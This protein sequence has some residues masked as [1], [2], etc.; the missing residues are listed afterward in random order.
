MQTIGDLIL[1][2]GILFSQSGTTPEDRKEDMSETELELV[3][4]QTLI[5]EL[6]ERF[7]SCI[8][9]GIPFQHS[10][11]STI[12]FV[13]NRF[14]C[15]GLL[16]TASQILFHELR[17]TSHRESSGENNTDIDTNKGDQDATW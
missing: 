13:G 9:A 10:A 11:E 16:M 14:S 1:Y 12:A 8:I 3:D 17:N 15:I 6:Q 7:D 5:K 4:T 2:I